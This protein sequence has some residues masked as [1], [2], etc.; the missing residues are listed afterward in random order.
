MV[1]PLT[2]NPGDTAIAVVGLGCRFPGGVRSLDD[3]GA[4]LT[5]G[6]GV[7]R[8]V[9][10]TRWD[11]GPDGGL[12]GFLDEVDRFDAAYFGIAPREA[13]AMDPQQRLML[14]VAWEAMSDSGRPVDAWRGTRTAAFF[15]VFSHDYLTLHTKT[16][17]LGGVG[18]HYGSGNEFSFVA[19]RLAYTF[20]LRGPMASVTTACSSSLLAVHLASQSLRRGESDVALAGGVS[21]MLTPEL[22][23]FMSQIGAISPTGRCRPFAAD[24]DGILRGDGCG[25][26]VLKRLSDALADQD[27]V[28]AVVRAS[29]ANHDG[30]SLGITAPNGAAQA[31]L[32][33]T[34]LGAAGIGP[35]DLDYVEA[36]GTG[37]PLGDQVELMAL[38]EVYGRPRDADRPALYVGSNK[39]VFGHTDAAAGI[40]GLLKGLYV[41]KARRVPA[42]PDPGRLTS[43]VA[44]DRGRMAVPVEP[45]SLDGLDRPV[46]V[47]V[48]S[49]GLSGTN[50]H[51]IAE[52]FAAAEAE[53]AGARP[54]GPYVLLA[55]AFH[56]AGLAEQVAGMGAR[57]ADDDGLG[58][59]PRLGRDPAYPRAAPVRR[60]RHGAAGIP[61]CARGDR[62]CAGR[63]LRRR[64]RSRRRPGD[65]VRL[66]RPG[67][68]V[69]R[70]GRGSV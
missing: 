59:L 12:G 14:E 9:P 40:A 57:A 36:H 6:T 38:D 70:H 41:I 37:T 63:R 30:R 51:V 45:V 28:Y 54:S 21:L 53:P 34:T 2:K 4:A 3:F 15:G 11:S 55:S 69:G 26:L 50:V 35:S 13:G 24:A 20:D 1:E 56:E 29:A 8:D 64:G 67:L 49:S 25:V 5:A 58:D 42:Q 22:T 47:A 18:P 62:G 60:R 19:G 33:R 46:R 23:A 48:S 66:L 68:A 39:A 10:A 44:W 7:F 52:G 65:G 17:G 16:L 27:R 43:A 61:R 32:L 31:E